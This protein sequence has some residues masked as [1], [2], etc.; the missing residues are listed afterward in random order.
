MLLRIAANGVTPIPAPTRTAIS[1][2]NTSS[3]A[4]PNGPSIYTRG[5]TFLSDGSTLGFEVFESILTTADAPPPSL[6]PPSSNLQPTALAKAFVK[7]PT[8][9]I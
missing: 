3:D 2:L 8:Q 1:Y 5:S 9:R 4:L 7:F 6:L